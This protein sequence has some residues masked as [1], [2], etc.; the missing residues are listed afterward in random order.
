ML[1]PAVSMPPAMA[2]NVTPRRVTLAEL[3]A[4]SMNGPKARL[5]YYSAEAA[6]AR[7]D[8][9]RAQRIGT[10]SLTAFVAPSPD[11]KCANVDCTRTSPDDA[12]LALSGVFGGMRVT[13]VQPVYTFG[14]LGAVTR[15]AKFAARAAMHWQ[16]A[17]AG[18]IAV[19]VGKAYYGLKLARELVMMLEDG[20]V[21]IDKAIGTIRT[22][23]AAGSPEVTIQ[24]RLRVQVLRAEVAA[25]LTE[26]REA[27]AIALA[28]IRALSG[29]SKLDIDTGPLT[30]T[31]FALAPTADA[32]IG[33]A[34]QK[35]PEIR[36]AK[37]AAMAAKHWERYQS[38]R[39]LPDFVL[40]GSVNVARAQGVD[41]PPSAFARDPF[42]TTTAA[43]GLALKWTI[44]PMGQRARVRRARAL[45]GRA[46]TLVAAADTV[47]TFEVRKA[48]A[49]ALMASRRV[50]AARRG[51]KSAKGWVASVLQAEA[52]GT[53]AAK[54]LADA[55]IAFFTLRARLLS[56][57]YQWNLAIVRLRRALGEFSATHKRP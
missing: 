31:T 33:R 50:I 17:V 9:A 55:Y 19:D 30:E 3:L 8:E 28:G 29:E 15:A 38:A 57:V 34:Q 43:L 18:N 54:D 22:K 36:A 40:V 48:H 2:D 23:L 52:I 37:A 45:A 56:S 42:N 10:F 41:N 32:Y 51:Y 6:R 20:L 24:D 16:N 49:Q 25:R 11:V 5:A 21:Q 27:E 39:Y 26:A 44:D 46:R 13:A 35:R 53:L 4:L 14:K 7:S 47:A 1:S 12:T